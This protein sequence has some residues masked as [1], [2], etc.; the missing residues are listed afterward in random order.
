MPI[1]RDIFLPIFCQFVKSSL[2]R[3]LNNHVFID[4]DMFYNTCLQ[5]MNYSKYNVIFI[6]FMLLGL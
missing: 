6:P 3:D 5:L 1:A 4:S 2:V